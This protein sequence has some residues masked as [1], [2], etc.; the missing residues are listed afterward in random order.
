MGDQAQRLAVDGDLR[1]KIEAIRKVAMM[2][3][4]G[5]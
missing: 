4:D 3:V 2:K 1:P 5:H